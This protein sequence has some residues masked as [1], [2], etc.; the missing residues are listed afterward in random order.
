MVLDWFRARKMIVFV[1]NKRLHTPNCGPLCWQFGDCV[2]REGQTEKYEN[3]FMQPCWSRTCKKEVCAY[4]NYFRVMQKA[5][6]LKMQTLEAISYFIYLMAITRPEPAHSVYILVKLVERL[7]AVYCVAVQ[8][9]LR[10]I[11]DTK[12]FG[13]KLRDPVTH[14]FLLHVLVQTGVAMLQQG[15]LLVALCSYGKCSCV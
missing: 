6:R 1:R 8:R 3:I 7:T 10:Y 11:L 4:V 13:F 9:L 15:S 2:Y 5:E 14:F 12:H